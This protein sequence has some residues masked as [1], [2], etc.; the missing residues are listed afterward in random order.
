[1]DDDVQVEFSVPTNE[2][3][4]PQITVCAYFTVDV[5]PLQSLPIYVSRNDVYII[6]QFYSYTVIIIYFILTA[7]KLKNKLL[8]YIYIYIDL[9][10]GY[11]CR[12]EN[13]N[14]YMLRGNKKNN[15]QHSSVKH[16]SI[17]F[18]MIL[19]LYLQYIFKLSGLYLF[20]SDFQAFFRINNLYPHRFDNNIL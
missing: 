20:V 6:I 18:K 2:Y 14:M 11:F 17:Q 3:P 10:V 16:V 13:G 1:M 7:I 5:S 12:C 8:G 9:W 15:F 19:G 4:I